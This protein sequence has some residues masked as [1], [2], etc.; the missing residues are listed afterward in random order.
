MASSNNGAAQTVTSRWRFRLGS[1]MLFLS[2]VGPL[3]FIPVLPTIG[4]SGALTAS[5]SGAVLVGA[6]LLMVAA[7]AVMGKE[8]YETIKGY[9]SNLLKQY[10]PPDEVSSSR[11]KV[12]LTMFLVPILFGWFSPYLQNF[13]IDLSG[14]SLALAI[15]GDLLLLSSLFVLGGDFWDKLRSLF[16]HDARAIFAR[17]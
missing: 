12:G 14:W 3:V 13:I 5:L 16:L 2:V 4:L 11:Y 6:E 10:G 1:A 9:V 15:V 17:S 7:V 8:G